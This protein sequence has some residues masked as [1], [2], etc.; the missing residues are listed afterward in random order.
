MEEKSYSTAIIHFIVH[1]YSYKIDKKSIGKSDQ[2]KCLAL[3]L[4]IKIKST[5]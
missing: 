2:Q 5:K 1:D 4:G 3:K